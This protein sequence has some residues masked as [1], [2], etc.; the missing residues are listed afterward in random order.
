MNL[1]KDLAE[2]EEPK[3]KAQLQELLLEYQ[4]IFFSSRGRSRED[5]CYDAQDRYGRC[6]TRTTAV[7]TSAT[8]S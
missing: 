1:L 8:A 4:D 5:N 7:A 6:A 3:D 2:E